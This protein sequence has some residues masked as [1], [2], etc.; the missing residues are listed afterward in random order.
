MKAPGMETILVVDDVPADIDALASERP[1][2]KAWSIDAAIDYIHTQSGLSFD[3]TVVTLFDTV[4]PEVIEIN[5][6]LADTP[7]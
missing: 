7:C 3:P 2:K 6:R 1:Y 4:L 5:R